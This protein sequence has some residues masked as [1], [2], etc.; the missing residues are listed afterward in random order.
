[1]GFEIMA[2]TKCVLVFINRQSLFEVTALLQG[3]PFCQITFAI[4]N[5][6]IRGALTL[7]GKKSCVIW[8]KCVLHYNIP[9]GQE[10]LRKL[11]QQRLYRPAEH[12][13]GS[14]EIVPI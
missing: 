8:E 2:V 9:C 12:Q 10:T 1:M 13:T 5:I 7:C 14:T 3:I 11:C 6:G 4:D